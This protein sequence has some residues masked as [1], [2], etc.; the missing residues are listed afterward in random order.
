MSG[1]HAAFAPASQK[2]LGFRLRCFAIGKAAGVPRGYDPLVAGRFEAS[3][4]GRQ[5]KRWKGEREAVP[6]PRSLSSP[7]GRG[8][9]PAQPSNGFLN[10]Q[11]DPLHITD[12]RM[13]ACRDKRK[14]YAGPDGQQN[15]QNRILTDNLTCAISSFIE[16]KYKQERK[17]SKQ[18][19]K[20]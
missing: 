20:P 1:K 8:T 2:R 3:E 5:R 12:L 16:I 17:E 4:K 13:L 19:A 14:V 6:P 15:R 11:P 9:M 7:L 18:A 10:T